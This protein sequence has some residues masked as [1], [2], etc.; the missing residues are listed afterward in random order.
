M[1]GNKPLIELEI[2]VELP[3]IKE[4]SSIKEMP[5]V[6]TLLNRK[7]ADSTSTATAATQ[8]ISQEPTRITS[9]NPVKEPSNSSPFP[10]QST[11]PSAATKPK[12]P[13][14]AGTLIL[15]KI[16]IKALPK[17][18]KSHKKSL[19]N[20]KLDCLGYFSTHFTE[21][22]LLLTSEPPGNLLGQ[23]G[24]GNTNL[25]TQIKNQKLDSTTVPT[26]F[27]LLEKKEFF[28]GQ[29]SQL[30]SKDQASLLNLGFVQKNKALPLTV[31]IAPTY[32]KK[33]PVGVWVCA[34]NNNSQLSE[35]E[36]KELKKILSDLNLKD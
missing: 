8:D 9:F 25:V 17:A 20:R 24:F 23:I 11:K 12:I 30:K 2:P 13:E 27:E 4:E 15:E 10:T 35:K 18:L 21:I 31:L 16:E 26:I 14:F 3:E 32:F 6:T 28:F 7:K 29:L 22:A 34:I 36:R 19:N 5:T 33:K 1:S